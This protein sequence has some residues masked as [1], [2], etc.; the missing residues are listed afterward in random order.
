MLSKSGVKVLDFGLAKSQGDDTLTGANVLVGTPGYMAPEQKEG[1][2]ARTDI[3]VLGLVLF[4]M[5]A[6][7]RR[8]GHEMAPLTETLS[9][10]MSSN[11][12]WRTIPRNAGNP[13]ETSAGS[14]AGRRKPRLFRRRAAS[15]FP[16][17]Y[18]RR[19]FRRNTV[20]C[21]RRWP[22][23]HQL[24]ALEL[25]LSPHSTHGLDR[26][27]ETLGGRRSHAKNSPSTGPSQAGAFPLDFLGWCAVSR[28][29]LGAFL[30]GLSRQVHRIADSLVSNSLELVVRIAPGMAGDPEVTGG[31]KLPDASPS[32]T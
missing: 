21:L 14:C 26:S 11:A 6:G 12:A 32:R 25:L 4:E 23:P 3:Y 9:S 30:L 8:E 10:R 28:I 27:I 31:R 17:T 2:D 29:D 18:H 24:S 5:T 20:R 19:Q 7:R 15:A 22:L 13:P 16:N 1:K